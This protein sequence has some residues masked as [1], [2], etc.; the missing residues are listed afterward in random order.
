MKEPHEAV[1]GTWRPHSVLSLDDAAIPFR[2]ALLRMAY[3]LR[4]AITVG[5]P[6]PVVERM[7]TRIRRPQPGDLV[8]EADA[9]MQRSTPEQRLHGLGILIETRVELMFTEQERREILAAGGAGDEGEVTAVAAY[10]QYGPKPEDICR[11]TD[12]DLIVLPVDLWRF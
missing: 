3:H 11:W 1:V 10:L 7:E 2:D 9:L 4:T 5:H 12:F 6:A 8:A